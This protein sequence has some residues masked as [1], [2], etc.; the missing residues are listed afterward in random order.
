MEDKY[1]YLNPLEAINL[2]EHDR[3]PGTITALCEDAVDYLSNF[4]REMV[5]DGVPVYSDKRMSSDLVMQYYGED[6]CE[7]VCDMW[8][9]PYPAGKVIVVS[10][11]LWKLDVIRLA[12]EMLKETA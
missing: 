12:K 2:A 10:G 11:G 8:Y 3:D 1:T 9:H 7:L 5:V 6:Y 4:E